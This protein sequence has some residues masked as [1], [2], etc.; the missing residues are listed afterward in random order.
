M[1]E[2]LMILLGVSVAGTVSFVFLLAIQSVFNG[3]RIWYYLL[4]KLLLLF[5]LFPVFILAII[6]FK[7]SIGGI[8]VLLNGPDFVKGYLNITLLTYTRFLQYHSLFMKIGIIWILGMVITLFLTL[9]YGQLSLYKLYKKADIKEENELK[10]LCASIRKE[11]GIKKNV[12]L[13]RCSS[14]ISPFTSGI[15]FPVIILPD[16]TYNQEEWKMLLKHEFFHLKSRDVLFKQLVTWIRIVHW[17]NPA[18]Y[19]FGK[20]VFEAAEMACDEKVIGNAPLKEKRFYAELILAILERAI[21]CQKNIMLAG[22]SNNEK[23]LKRRLSNFMQ[24]KSLSRGKK[25][26]LFVISVLMIVTCPVVGY[27]SV[28]G[29]LMGQNNS[30]ERVLS[31]AVEVEQMNDFKEFT[32]TVKMTAEESY[33][34]NLSVRGDN[35]IDITIE[36]GDRFWIDGDLNSTSMDISLTASSSSDSFR[37]GYLKGSTAKYVNSSKGAVN[38]SFTI[39][40]GSYSIYIE[41][42]SDHAIHVSGRITV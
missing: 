4:I 42:L 14:V 37:V 35:W 40:P 34:M 5:Y 13:L 23:A 21:E 17:F 27:A 8:E 6:A 24:K 38:Y 33:S 3:C 20:E 25:V 9:L 28:T 19:F 22:F 31:E 26:L 7:S 16:V 36:A 10:Q 15:F 39:V 2:F 29:I 32:G 18:I 30:T 41:N 11:L 1:G 12:K